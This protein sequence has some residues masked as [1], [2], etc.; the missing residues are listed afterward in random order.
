MPLLSFAEIPSTISSK[1]EGWRL[2][3]IKRTDKRVKIDD[4]LSE[5][6]EGL[7]SIRKSFGK[8]ER[9]EDHSGQTAYQFEFMKRDRQ[10]GDRVL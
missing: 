1:I 3:F 9:V 6:H 8:P 2:E 5:R 4:F 10:E 7:C